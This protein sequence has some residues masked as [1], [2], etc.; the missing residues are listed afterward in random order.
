MADLLIAGG[1][2]VDG[3]GN[4]PVPGW[5][6]ID[7]ERITA[8]GRSG[9]VAPD[10]VRTLIATDSVVAPGFVDVHNHSDL[11]PF[12]LPSMP[13]TLRQG[14]TTVVVGNCGSSPWPSAGWDEAVA[15][16]YGDPAA[17]RAPGWQ[18]W[19]DY[20]DAIDRAQPAVN[21]ATL[22]G[23]GSIR[24]EVLGHERRPPTAAELDRM[25]SFV[26]DAIVD[27][28]IG[29]IDRS[30]LRARDLRHYRRGRLPRPGGG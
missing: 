30:D 24:L 25:R 28:A 6:A 27:G 19:A 10:A 26:R 4:P 11:S 7:D 8:V 21:I 15:L 20:L 12:V 22:V 23:H 5:V 3:T 2:V 13:S 29:D 1:T 16:A 17:Q 9:D 14:V 18:G